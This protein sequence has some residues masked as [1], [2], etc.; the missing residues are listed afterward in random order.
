MKIQP[1]HPASDLTIRGHLAATA[2]QGLLANPSTRQAIGKDM[3]TSLFRQQLAGL[4]VQYADTL[5]AELNK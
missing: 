2:L 5:I 3:Q 4:S 1:G